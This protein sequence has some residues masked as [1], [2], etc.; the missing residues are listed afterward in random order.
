QQVIVSATAVSTAARGGPPLDTVGSQQTT[1]HFNVGDINLSFGCIDLGPGIT[2][3]LNFSFIADNGFARP[4]TWQWIGTGGANI[5]IGNLSGGSSSPYSPVAGDFTN[6]E[7]T[8]GGVAVLTLAVTISNGNGS[9]T[10]YIEVPVHLTASYC[11]GTAG[12]GDSAAARADGLLRPTSYWKRGPAMGTA[13]AGRTSSLAASAA[14]P[15]LQIKA[16]DVSISPSIPRPGDTLDVRFKVSNLG[17][18]AATEVPIALQI[19]GA[20]L[21]TETYSLKAGAST[22]GAFQ[23]TIPAS[24]D[25]TTVEGKVRPARFQVDGSGAEDV[26]E[27]DV[28]RPARNL[29]AA[30]LVIDPGGSV[31]QRSTSNKMVA[32]TKAGLVSP[33]DGLSSMPAE[34]VYLEMNT[35]CSGFR[36]SSGA[37]VDCDG[38]ADL[39]IAIEDFKSSGFS[40]N[41]A[42]GVADLG[43]VDPN[44]ADSTGA[45]FNANAS[46]VLG[47]TYAVQTTGGKIGYV[48]FSASLTPRQLEAEAKRRFGLNGVRILRKLGGDNGSTTAGDV[49]GRIS[50]DALMYFDMTFRP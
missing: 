27:K 11:L 45:R 17:D 10:K 44:A 1:L 26:V 19:N 28:R 34:R 31:K 3:S 39:D 20:T 50:Q 33:A 13:S 4:I 16:I 6:N 42:L 22:L 48:K 5:T 47:H 23:V 12:R 25:P 7:T 9:A 15:D 30:Q 36:M 21:A 37:V 8:A 35:V 40:L 29:L 38:G 32:L 2:K 24:G 14:M 41:A 46:L 43:I 49:S 18:G